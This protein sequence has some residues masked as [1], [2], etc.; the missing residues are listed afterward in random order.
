M[1]SIIVPVYNVEKY[2]GKC[3]ESILHQTYADFELILVNDGSTDTS[4]EIC[5]KYAEKDER[6]RLINKENGGLSSAR[7]RGI[8]VCKGDFITFVDSD[9]YISKFMLSEL[10]KYIIENSADIS[11]CSFKRVEEFEEIK[12]IKVSGEIEILSSRNCFER[13]YS[14]Q[15]DEFT[16]AWGKLYKRKLFENI[17][18]PEGKIH[19]D[20][21]V[22][23]KLFYAANKIV[24]LNRKLYFY[25]IR[26]QSI[27][28]STFSKNSLVRLDAYEERVCF[29][30]QIK[31][32]ELAALTSKRFIEK[33][34]EY[35]VLMK[36][37]D[38]VEIRSRAV[39]LYNTYSKYFFYEGL[40]EKITIITFSKNL[41]LFWGH[42]FFVKSGIRL[43]A[44]MKKLKG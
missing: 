35:Y 18:Y 44:L 38:K 15:V 10:Y 22:T 26:S 21:F 28:H 12:D 24:Y 30:E 16:V 37:N 4:Y 6:I 1:I 11:M 29:F 41:T 9:D 34:S 23:Y 20:E 7:N 25:L 42:Y 33:A 40:R 8:D 13:I 5:C 31:E 27:M 3:I 43:K 2:V 32:K 17:R 36:D 14:S 19:E 39:N